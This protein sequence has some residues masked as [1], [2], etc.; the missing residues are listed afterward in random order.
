MNRITKATNE[1]LKIATLP[2]RILVGVVKAVQKETPEHLKFPYE[3]RKKP[4]LKE[5][6]ND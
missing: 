4:N 5:V 6:I 2:I 1:L 3:V